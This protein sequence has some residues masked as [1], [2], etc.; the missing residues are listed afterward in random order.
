MLTVH[1]TAVIR[2]SLRISAVK[3]G[4][5]FL[6]RAKKRLAH[7]AVHAHMVGGDTGLTGTEK[8]SPRDAPSGEFDL[9]IRADD[10]GTFAAQF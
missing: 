6:Q 1:N 10:G 7:T 9:S 3:F 5:G 8:L 4:H 2:T